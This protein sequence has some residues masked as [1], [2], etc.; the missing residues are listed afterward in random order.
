MLINTINIKR[1]VYG[2]F[3]VFV[4]IYILS[5]FLSPVDG[6]A[7]ARYNIN[8]L[9]MRLLLTSILLPVVAIWACTA[10]GFVHFKQYALSIKGSAP[11][12]GTNTIANGLGVIALQMIVSG[13]FSSV[14]S[15]DSI[16][17][18]LGGEGGVEIISTALAIIF[19]LVSA[20]LLYLGA[21]QLNASLAKPSKPKILTNS[22]YLLL[23]VNLA[24]LAV[25]VLGYPTNGT[26]ESVYKY[27][28]LSVAILGIWAPYF[29]VWTVYLLATKNLHH[30]RHHVKGKVYKKSLGLLAT[31]V[32]F[33]LGSSVLIQLLGAISEVF[34]EA[35]LL[36]ILIIIY[37]LIVVLGLGY[38]FIARAATK[39]R[40]V[41]V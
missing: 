37:P 31:G 25:I 22:F 11:G 26:T 39:L 30:Y 32:Y 8:E 41:E 9:Q 36:A 33:I 28:P 35:K 23:A 5:A 12:K 17:R 27:I 20:F 4:V 3:A 19:A 13:S 24:F 40:G 38:L 16:K 10:Y 15:N 34:A 1:L 2:S 14:A 7:L 21:S 6:E 29:I 18:A